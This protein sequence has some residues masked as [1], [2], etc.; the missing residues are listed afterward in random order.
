M[1]LSLPKWA[2]LGFVGQDSSPAADVHVGPPVPGCRRF[3]RTK[4]GSWR[5][6]ADLEVCPTTAAAF[7]RPPI[8]WLALT[9]HVA[10][11]GVLQKRIQR[12]HVG[13]GQP[14]YAVQKSAL[15]EVGFQESPGGV[16]DQVSPAQGRLARSEEHT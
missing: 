8:S 4:S 1:P 12:R 15:H 14:F 6:R 10:R 3:G 5:T 2:K 11:L 13:D 16:A 7:T 9:A